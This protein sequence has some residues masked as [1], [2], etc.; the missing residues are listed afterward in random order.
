M[1]RGQSGQLVRPAIEDLCIFAR[2]ALKPFRRLQIVHHRFEGDLAL[3]DQRVPMR[4]IESED[5]GSE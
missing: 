2:D 4:S 5:G 3:V 1:P